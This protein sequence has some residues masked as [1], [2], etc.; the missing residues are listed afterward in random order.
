M[1]AYQVRELYKRSKITKTPLRKME[2]ICNLSAAFRTAQ[3][4]QMQGQ[5]TWSVIF[6]S[7][8]GDKNLNKS[9][10]NPFAKITFIN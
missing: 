4:E 6:D 2:S 3:T 7:K 9:Q 10:I 8:T 1:G 5:E